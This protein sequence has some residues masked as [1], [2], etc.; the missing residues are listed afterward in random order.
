[1]RKYARIQDSKVFEFIETDGNITEM[2][3]PSL[4]WVE[5]TD[6]VKVGQEYI[7]QQ[8]SD[9]V[10]EVQIPSK[11][12]IENL[13]L[14]AYSNPITGSDRYFSEAVALQAEGFAATSTEVKDAKAVGLAR[15]LEIKALYPY[16]VI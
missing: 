5:V 8:F 7:N 14:T 3:H 15:K 1:M 6:S 10:E 9:Y 16:P 2:F 4:L 12:D 13:R 11:E